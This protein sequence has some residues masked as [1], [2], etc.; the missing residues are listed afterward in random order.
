MIIL[1][2][3]GDLKSSNKPRVSLK[4]GEATVN[5]WQRFS[6]WLLL[7]FIME[8]ASHIEERWE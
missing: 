4:F 5:G 3:T 2:Y 8:G 7:Q 1:N 6:N